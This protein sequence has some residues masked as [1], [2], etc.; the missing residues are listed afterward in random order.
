MLLCKWNLTGPQ[1]EEAVLASPLEDSLLNSTFLT[2]LQ[3][4][5]E[6]NRESP[7]FPEF[8]DP[9]DMRKYP[10]YMN[11]VH[12]Q[13]YINRIL[14]RLG[15]QYYRSSNQLLHEIEMISRN[16]SSFNEHH[17]PIANHG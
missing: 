5:V 7:F 10:S 3:S 13:F 8:L 14:K 9:V 4:H 1:G 16:V 12:V 6:Q 11:V 17:S 2:D 15:N